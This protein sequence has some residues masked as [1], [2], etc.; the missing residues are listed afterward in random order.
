[1]GRQ[2]LN[3]SSRIEK[4]FPSRHVTLLIML[5]QIIWSWHCPLILSSI[6]LLVM[7]SEQIFEFKVNIQPHVAQISSCWDGMRR[8]RQETY[9]QN[10]IFYR[11]LQTHSRTLWNDAGACMEFKYFKHLGILWVLNAKCFLQ[12]F[13]WLYCSIVGCWKGSLHSHINQTSRTRLQRSV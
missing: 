8:G 4:P 13:V 11:K 3:H 2:F 6:T 1:M 10:F 12:C 7:E 9:V 5:L